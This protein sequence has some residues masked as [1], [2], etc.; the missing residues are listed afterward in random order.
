M[1]IK[2]STGWRNDGWV[3]SSHNVLLATL[4]MYK[5]ILKCS[6]AYIWVF[7][8][9]LNR[10]NISIYNTS[11]FVE[12]VSIYK[13]QLFCRGSRRLGI[14]KL[15]LFLQCWRG[16]LR[17]PWPGDPGKGGQHY[18][19]TEGGYPEYQLPHTDPYIG[20]GSQTLSPGRRMHRDRNSYSCFRIIG[21]AWSHPNLL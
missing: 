1:Y 5:N 3:I 10:I 12:E 16:Q 11:Y 7:Y 13:N 15:W 20:V 19:G 9:T 4:S 6:S 17:K 21:L 2:K 8:I 18:K 14:Q